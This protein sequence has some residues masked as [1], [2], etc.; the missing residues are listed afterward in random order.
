MV[1]M[2]STAPT[3]TVVGYANA[4]FKKSSNSLLVNAYVVD[5][6]VDSGSCS[7]NVGTATAGN[8]T[9]N[10]TSNWCNL[11]YSLAGRSS[12]GNQIVSVYG[13]DSLK[14]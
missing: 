13:N 1:R 14:K 6:G 12:D 11:S 10:L 9:T 5:A 7:I 3:V 4:T 2:D 8:M